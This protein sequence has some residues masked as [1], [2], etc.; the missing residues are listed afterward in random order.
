LTAR[1]IRHTSNNVPQSHVCLLKGTSV[2]PRLP[3]SLPA[4]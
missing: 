2:V 3:Q 4:P 1:A